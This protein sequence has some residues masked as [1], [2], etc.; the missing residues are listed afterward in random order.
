MQDQLR[1]LAGIIQHVAELTEKN[2]VNADPDEMIDANEALADCVKRFIELSL[3]EID[4]EKVKEAALD[5]MGLM[6]DGEGM[7]SL[8]FEIDNILK[9]LNKHFGQDRFMV[10]VELGKYPDVTFWAAPFYWTSYDEAHQQIGNMEMLASALIPDYGNPEGYTV[11][12]Q[13]YSE[14]NLNEFKKSRKLT[15]L[16][17]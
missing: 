7:P 6:E 3:P 14:K 5:V 16:T 4:E 17:D 12:L 10:V 13:P 2:K 15:D 9:I 1:K 11:K 8:G